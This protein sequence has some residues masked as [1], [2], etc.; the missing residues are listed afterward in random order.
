MHSFDTMS[1]NSLK[2]LILAHI[3]DK[4]GMIRFE[5]YM[6]LA[7]Y[8]PGLG[9][10]SSNL[11]KFG[12]YG[13]FVTAPELGTTFASCLAKQCQQIFALL[14]QHNI[15]EIGA[16]SGQLAA[17]LINTLGSNLD[18]Y[19]ILELSADLQQ[20]QKQLAPTAKHIHNL[21]EN[22]SGIIIANEVLDAMP[23]TRFLYN[24]DGLQEYYVTKD[25]TFATENPTKQLTD[26]FAKCQLQQYFTG[27]Y[28]SEVN[29]WIPGWIT[30]LSSCLDKGAILLF[31]YGFP[32]HE[33]YH[34]QRNTG[35]LMCHHKHKTHADPLYLPGQQDITAHV[36]FTAVA[37]AATN[38]ELDIAGYTS[39]ASFLLNCGLSYDFNNKR[40][41]TV[42]INMLT[43]PAEMGELFKAIALSKN[44][45]EDLMG[46]EN[47]DR[48]HTL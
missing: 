4:G 37:E 33:Y 21:P 29:L 12:K 40:A 47:N 26:Y 3:I 16:G 42:E 45:R 2:D 11:R 19:Y 31:D 25:F 1:S 18:N 14:P 15:L 27:E 30:A 44:I 38:S 6:K 28:S 46:F 17:D 10:Y 22:F 23:V 48:T 32:R 20:R 43:S 5:D 39:L 9:Y 24:A 13:D 7:L 34:A 8:A 36:D 41:K 35:T